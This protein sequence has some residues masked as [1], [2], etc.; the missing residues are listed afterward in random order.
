MIDLSYVV[1][2]QPSEVL[3]SNADVAVVGDSRATK[4]SS[5]VMCH[6][7]SASL[8][9]CCLTCKSLLLLGMRK[10]LQHGC[11]ARLCLFR[12][13]LLTEVVIV[14][15]A[16]LLPVLLWQGDTSSPQVSQEASSKHVK[17]PAVQAET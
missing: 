16:V 10:E 2:P 9:F 5:E 8:G 6:R 1:F 3:L 13:G 14:A 15:P 11:K 4:H 17:E 7:F 12:I